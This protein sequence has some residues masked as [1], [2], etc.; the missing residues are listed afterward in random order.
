MMVVLMCA[1]CVSFRVAHTAQRSRRE[2]SVLS[3]SLNLLHLSP[4]LALVSRSLSFPYTHTHKQ[5]PRLEIACTT[6]S[7]ASLPAAH[8]RHK[9]LVLPRLHAAGCVRGVAFT[10]PGAVLPAGVRRR[11]P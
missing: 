9:S 4:S 1:C 11:F 6:F 5:Y 7:C 10:S 8:A 2:Q 3:L